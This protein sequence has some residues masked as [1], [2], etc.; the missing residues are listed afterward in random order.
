MFVKILVEESEVNKAKQTEIKA[1]HS[2]F[3]PPATIIAKAKK[4]NP[5]VLPANCPALNKNKAPAKPAI[6]EDNKTPIH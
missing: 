1:I 4:P 6:A 3:H 2:I 5:A